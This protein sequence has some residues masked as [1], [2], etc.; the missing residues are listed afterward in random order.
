[1]LSYLPE[2][3]RQSSDDLIL[4][5]IEKKSKLREKPFRSI[6][7]DQPTGLHRDARK[8]VASPAE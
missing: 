6:L 5:R 7:E 8:F 1:M 3:F 2:T 4:C